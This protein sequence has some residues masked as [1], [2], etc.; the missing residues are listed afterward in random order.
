MEATSRWLP[1]Q[2]P[3]QSG[4]S[5]RLGLAARVLEKQVT[6]AIICTWQS[7]PKHT[8]KGTAGPGSGTVFIRHLILR[9]SAEATGAGPG[10]EAVLSTIQSGPTST[11]ELVLRMR[12]CEW[13][14]SKPRRERDSSCLKELTFQLLL[15]ATPGWQ[16][17]TA[18]MQSWKRDYPGEK[19]GQI[20]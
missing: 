17:T 16:Q 19:S 7:K 18:R 8:L 2:L 9:L 4:G 1:L 5:A 20:P 11:V 14:Q 13:L 15:R 12:C 6:G 10:R 3:V